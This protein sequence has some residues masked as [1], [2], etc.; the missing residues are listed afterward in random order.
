MIIPRPIT[1]V[2]LGLISF[3]E[4]NTHRR[5]YP[6]HDRKATKGY[7]EGKTIFSLIVKY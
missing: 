1:G 3:S 5:R 2:P 6:A 7:H 4:N